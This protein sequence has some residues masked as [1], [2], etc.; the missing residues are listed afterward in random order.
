MFEKIMGGSNL[1]RQCHENGE[2]YVFLPIKITFQKFK[3]PSEAWDA[4]IYRIPS[5][6]NMLQYLDV[7]F[8]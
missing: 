2:F 6:N 4:K 3:R 1:L 8:S 5:R 7:T